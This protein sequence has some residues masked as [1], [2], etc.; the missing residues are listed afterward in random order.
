MY[1]T[2]CGALNNDN[3]LKC[4]KCGEILNQETP[5]YAAGDDNTIAGIIPYKNKFALISYYVSYVSILPVI[6][7]AA[8]IA[9]VF[10][11]VKA[12]AFAKEHPEFKGKIHAW[13]GIII[14][15][16]FGGINLIL[17]I[18]LVLGGLFYGMRRY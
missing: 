11:G 16:I 12:L 17:I 1:C 18:I 6:G 8:G 3:D 5:K 10:Y 13:A 15:I 9:A 2:K 7:L 14:G 4:V